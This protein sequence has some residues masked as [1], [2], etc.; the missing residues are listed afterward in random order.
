MPKFKVHITQTVS[1]TVEVEAD[2]VQDAL[3]SW[4]H[5]PDAPGSITHGAF[6]GVTVDEAG[7]WGAVAVYDDTGEEVW[8]GEREENSP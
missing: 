1:T 5:S 8:T 3:D 6:G 2:D 4:Y 7:E